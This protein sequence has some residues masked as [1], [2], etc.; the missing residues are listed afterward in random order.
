[1][2]CPLSLRCFPLGRFSPA[3]ILLSF[4]LLFLCL[5][6]AQAAE[7][8]ATKAELEQLQQL[9]AM[10]MWPKISIR[11][12]L[13][14]E[15]SAPPPSSPGEETPSIDLLF[16]LQSANATLVANKESGSVVGATLKLKGVHERIVCFADRPYRTF[17]SIPVSDFFGY[18]LV[19]AF[20]RGPNPP[21]AIMAGELPVDIAQHFA[22]RDGDSDVLPHRRLLGAVLGAASYDANVNELEFQLPAGIDIFQADGST[23]IVTPE[24]FEE[25]EK[26]YAGAGNGD[27]PAPDAANGDADAL[28]ALQQVSLFIDSFG[29]TPR[30]VA[31]GGGRKLLQR[32]AVGRRGGG[33]AGFGRAGA[34]RVGGGGAVRPSTG[35]R[36][37]N[38]GVTNNFVR[39]GGGNVLVG[40]AGLGWG[41]GLY[42]NALGWGGAGVYGDPYYDPMFGSRALAYSQPFPQAVPVPVPVPVP[43]QTQT[44]ASVEPSSP[45]APALSVADVIAALSGVWRG[46]GGGKGMGQIVITTNEDG[47]TASVSASPTGCADCA[48]G[49]RWSTARG[50]V[51][52]VGDTATV[53]AT[54]NTCDGGTETTRATL[55]R[56]SNGQNVLYWTPANV[57]TKW[58]RNA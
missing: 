45:A 12:L 15:E 36:G 54:I 1:M 4:L 18:P 24:V 34:V 23:R 57:S 39:R 27:A 21:N 43:T 31:N 10:A 3:R 9:E 46:D 56:V 32:R 49:C 11:D 22:S 55:E 50:T 19:D 33:V 5:S 14:G 40:G 29:K 26:A 28:P 53:D 41:G 30:S 38:G 44:A 48:S 52:I 2:T 20:F 6:F 37:F 35:R 8:T 17:D 25:I 7:S 16:V 51:R 42:G 13:A 58:V 47:Q